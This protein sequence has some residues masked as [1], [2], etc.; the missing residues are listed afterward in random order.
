MKKKIRVLAIKNNT[1]GNYHRVVLPSSYFSKEDFLV[2][3]YPTVTETTLKEFCP[4]IIYIHWNSPVSIPQLSVWR[5]KYNFKVVTEIDDTWEGLPEKYKRVVFQSQNLCIFSDA[6]IC[7]NDFIAKQVG[8]FND[9]VFII[10]NYIPK[11]FISHED[12]EYDKKVKVGIYGSI[13]S[14]YD[15]W[16]SLKDIIEK[17]KVNKDIKDLYEFV[18]IGE[19]ED[20]RW[21]D[22][23][24]M[25]GK[26]NTTIFKHTKPEQSMNLLKNIDILLCP[27]DDSCISTGRS[28]LKIYEAAAK[29][30]IPII[31]ENYLKKDKKNELLP[32]LEADIVIGIIKDSF[33]RKTFVKEAKKIVDS[34]D[35]EEDCVRNRERIFRQTLTLIEEKPPASIYSIYYTENQPVEYIPFLNPVKTLK[36]K[37]YLFEYNPM[38]F[39]SAIAKDN[40]YFGIFSHKFPMKTGFYKKLVYD[41]IKN[42]K[43]DVIIFCKPIENYILTSKKNHPGIIEILSF[44]CFRLN[45]KFKEPKHVVYSNFFVTK[46]E[47]YKRYIKEVIKPSIQLMEQNPILCKKVWANSNYQS[48]NSE[49]LKKHTELDY[50]PFHSFVLER[51]FSIWLDNNQ[52]TVSTYF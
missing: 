37:S 46:G 45:L 21:K 44:I 19:D 26:Q 6:V 14:H 18:I 48:L 49:E 15:N 17:I 12:K 32:I 52:F 11:E 43:S 1:G 31:S 13:A 29:G 7:S 4:D 41:I 40:E 3:Y 25:F 20:K 35:Y 28:N 51:L 24:A 5:S 27:L 16:M 34:F 36:D 8:N 22:I 38:L 10:S 50:Y 39:L 42:E 9:N 30:C 2:K 47:L 33:I 23:K